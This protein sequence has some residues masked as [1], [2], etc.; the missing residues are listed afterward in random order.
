M[1]SAA[2]FEGPAWLE[3]CLACVEHALRLRRGKHD[4]CALCAFE[5][6][7]IKNLLNINLLDKNLTW[8]V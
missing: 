6:L 8:A 7:A 1:I 5:P 3:V 2:A 4:T